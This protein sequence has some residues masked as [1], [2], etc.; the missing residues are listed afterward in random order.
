[1]ERIKGGSKFAFLIAMQ[2]K[3]KYI[4]LASCHAIVEAVALQLASPHA[5][6]F[7]LPSLNSTEHSSTDRGQTTAWHDGLMQMDVQP[8]RVSRQ[9]MHSTEVLSDL[10]ISWSRAPQAAIPA[11]PDMIVIPAEGEG[12]IQAVGSKLLH[13]CH[14]VVSQSYFAHLSSE[15]AAELATAAAPAEAFL[16]MHVS[17]WE[18]YAR[19]MVMS[20]EQ[21]PHLT[22]ARSRWCEDCIPC[23][24]HWA[25]PIYCSGAL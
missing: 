11:A 23:D 14:I 19:E 7:C 17:G 12:A 9:P 20:S 15:S 4:L 22:G 25:L 24:G 10:S 21:R 1:M 3:P 2:W 16:H 8:V 5:T 6:L 13:K 18:L